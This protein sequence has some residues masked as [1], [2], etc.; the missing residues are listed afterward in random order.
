MILLVES[1]DGHFPEVGFDGSKIRKQ[2]IHD[3]QF[4]I[5]IRFVAPSGLNVA[6]QL[7]TERHL[8]LISNGDVVILVQ[9]DA[10]IEIVAIS[11]RESR[12]RILDAE[13]GLKLMKDIIDITHD[14]YV[15]EFDLAADHDV[16]RISRI[17]IVRSVVVSELIGESVVDGDHDQIRQHRRDGGALR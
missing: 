10:E 14:G 5:R 7:T 6:I 8:P 13:R 16:I 4:V 17:D 3:L 2:A 15:V 12:F 9:A 1:I 11:G